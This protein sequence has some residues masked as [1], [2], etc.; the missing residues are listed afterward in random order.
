ME[1]GRIIIIVG[2]VTIDRIGDKIIRIKQEFA[3]E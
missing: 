2:R 3:G 1:I